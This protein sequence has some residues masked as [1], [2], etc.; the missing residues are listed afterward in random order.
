[1]ERKENHEI[2][3]TDLVEKYIGEVA[4]EEVSEQKY[5]GFVLSNTG[6]NMANIKAM[7]KKS[8]GGIPIIMNK[9]ECL[10]LRE[11]F[12]ECAVILMKVI[13]RGSILSAGECYYNLTEIQLRN[14]ERIE[15]IYLKNISN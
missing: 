1:M 4:V 10:N 6:N 3:E 5:L 12:F 8:I 14:I 9:L 13:L 2:G 15:E 11:Y 7:N